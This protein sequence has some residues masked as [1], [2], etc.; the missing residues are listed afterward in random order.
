MILCETLCIH[1][2]LFTDCFCR[3]Q[4]EEYKKEIHHLALQTIQTAMAHWVFRK[5]V[6]RSVGGSR[7]VWPWNPV[8]KSKP[9]LY[10]IASEAIAA[11]RYRSLRHLR[12]EVERKSKPLLYETILPPRNKLQDAFVG[13]DAMMSM[14]GI[15]EEGSGPCSRLCGGTRRR[16][17]IEFDGELGDQ[18]EYEIEGDNS[19]MELTAGQ[20]E[21]VRAAY[22]AVVGGEVVAADPNLSKYFEGVASGYTDVKEVMYTLSNK[23]YADIQ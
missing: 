18:D 23:E 22:I 7:N 20:R 6:G 3:L 1:T 10:A 11:T 15:V 16:G 19:S 17:E 2:V 13:D 21:R 12:A 8:W 9:D 14:D 4:V 5:R